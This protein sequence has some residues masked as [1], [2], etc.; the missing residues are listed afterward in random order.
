MTKKDNRIWYVIA[1]VVVT[2]LIVFVGSYAVTLY[3]DT[4]KSV[5]AGTDAPTTDNGESDG[6]E[7]GGENTCLHE[8]DLIKYTPASCTSN[9][10]EK[11][12]CI[13]CKSIE[14]RTIDKFAHDYEKERIAPTCTLTGKVTYTCECGDG[15]EEII[16]PLGHVDQVEV[17]KSPTCTETGLIMHTCLDCGE[18][19]EE[20][21]FALGHTYEITTG[22]DPDTGVVYTY[23]TCT[24]CGHVEMLSEPCNH[25]DGNNDNICD[26]C[27]MANDRQKRPIIGE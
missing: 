13:H 17:V 24:K 18:S 5:D 19:Y 9:G 26:Y 16:E 7:Q 2:L 14:E 27:G 8:F 4:Y 1:C 20:T 15:Y 3:K 21:L 11:Y 6:G 10:Y 12:E 25:G 23:Y 22:A